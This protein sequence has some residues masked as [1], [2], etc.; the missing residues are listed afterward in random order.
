MKGVDKGLQVVPLLHQNLLQF[1]SIK[2]RKEYLYATQVKDK[3]MALGMDNLVYCWD[4]QTGE[5]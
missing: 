1:H 2:P 5:A 3:F 4:M